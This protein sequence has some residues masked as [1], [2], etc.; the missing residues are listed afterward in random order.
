MWRALLFPHYGATKMSILILE[1]RQGDLM[2][3]NGAPIRFRSKT[4]IELGGTARFLF[5]KQ[6]LRPEEAD[7]PAS[8]HLLCFTD[9]LCGH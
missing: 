4:R 5:G 9:C 8:P 6:I 3:I 2:I 7:T 1:L